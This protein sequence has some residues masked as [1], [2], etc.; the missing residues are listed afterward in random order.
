MISFTPTD[1]Q[2]LIIETVHRYATQRM[3]PAA[4]DA[5]ESRAAPA[6]VIDTGWELGLLPNA[7]PEAYGGFGDEHSAVTGVLAA[8]ELG[9]G[10][11]ATA[12]PEARSELPVHEEGR[13]GRRERFG[14]SRLRE[15]G[16][17]VRFR[18]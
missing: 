7:I 3:R 18:E 11:L 10:D 12:L 16:E 1:E 6:A 14:G 2:N 4:H 5:D 17:V 13:Q 9:Y 8:E 15:E